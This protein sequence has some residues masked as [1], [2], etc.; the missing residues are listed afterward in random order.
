MNLAINAAEAI[1]AVEGLITVRTGVQD[2]DERYMQLH[3]ETGE[4]R[5]G[6]Y[7]SLEVRDTGSGMDQATKA[8]VFDPFFSTKFTGR[9]LGLAAVAGILRGHKGAITVSSAPGQGSCFTALFPA[10]ERS[11]GRPP[12]APRDAALQGTGVI[13]V[14]DDEQMVRKMLKKALERHGYTVLMADGGSAAIDVFRRHPGEIALVV[15]DLSMPH[16]SGEEALAELVKIRPQVKVVVSSGYA[17]SQ[18][19]TLFQGQRVSGFIQKPFTSK[20]IAEK[21]KE[22]IG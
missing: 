11:A 22:C 13:L 21:V 16:M 10:A 3:L 18:V 4:L 19:M 12:A 8:K 9:G 14:V 1:G 6:K 7:V 15:L 17:E 5:P 20:G 2:V